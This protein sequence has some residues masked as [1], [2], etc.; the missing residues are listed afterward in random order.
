MR[1]DPQQNHQ[2]LRGNMSNQ[3]ADKNE[4]TVTI[5]VEAEPHEWPKNDDITYEQVVTLAVPDYPQQDPKHIYSVKYTK[6][7]GHKPEGILSPGSQPVKVK[8][9]MEFSATDTGQ[10]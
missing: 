10:S 8:E 3:E 4:K 7:H 9:G 1:R 5:Y 2:R 6:G